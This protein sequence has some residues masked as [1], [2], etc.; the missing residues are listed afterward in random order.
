V[1][2]PGPF[3]EIPVPETRDDALRALATS[4]AEARRLIV[5]ALERGT[6]EAIT[7]V[8]ARVMADEDW[9]VRKQAVHLAVTVAPRVDVIGPLVDALRGPSTEVALRNAAVEA[10]AAIG[11][12]AVE[13]V[14][15]ALNARAADGAPLLDA[16]GRKLAVEVL[17][18]SRKE[19]ALAPVIAALDDDDANVRAAAAEAVGLI[20]GGPAA[21]ALIGLLERPDRFLRLAA[22]EGLDRLGVPIPIDRLAPLVTDRILRH[23]AIAA[24]ARVRDPEAIPLLVRGLGDGS[25]HVAESALRSLGTL[26]GE[27]AHRARAQTELAFA[28]PRA[29]QR[30]LDAALSGDRAL[31][32]LALPVLSVL[33]ALG[34]QAALQAL[35]VALG[36]EELAESAERELREVGEPAIAALVDA[37][38]GDEP[39]TRA[40]VLRLL[41]KLRPHAP[42]ILP[43]ARHALRAR[44]I[45]SG[46]SVA[47]LDAQLDVAAAAASAIAL[48]AAAGVAPTNEDVTTLL[49]A[50][51][52]RTPRMAAAGLQALRALG[53]CAPQAVRPLLGEVEPTSEEAPIVCALLAV[54]GGVDDIGWLGRAVSAESPRTRRA[55]VEALAQIGGTSAAR[56]VALAVTDEVP[57]VSLAAVRAL[58]RLRG[59]PGHE[60][61][62]LLPLLHIMATADD[63]ATVSAAVRALGGTREARA[64]EAIRPLVRAEVPRLACAAVE[65]LAELLA[66]DGA[67]EV[68]ID[69]LGHPAPAVTRAGL[70]VLDALAERQ[71]ARI[72]APPSPRDPAPT[73]DVDGTA[74]ARLAR[75]LLAVSDLLSHPSWEVRR[76]AVEVITRLDPFGARPLLSA[77]LPLEDEPA[78]REVVDRALATPSRPPP[79]FAASPREAREGDG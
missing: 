39:R 27:P 76:R 50:A 23:A 1:T 67:R 32:Q 57:E 79:S 61:P 21:S 54:I 65:A 60:H 22:L 12:P 42:E 31:Q 59:A 72:D 25:R 43:L 13:A 56:A 26:L 7:G 33:G 46:T 28:T 64:V 73:S 62:G 71:E 63:E 75:T 14:E 18:G 58:G 37:A 77:R 15:R 11:L 45:Q 2:S 20:G 34:G 5:C 51:S 35:V 68:A 9:R 30:A 53:R 66:E 44:S 6:A 3:Q 74:R 36:D 47:G 29:R 78:V 16:D 69:A 24:L 41:P 38:R 49:R 70:D 52:S 48:V 19:R 10:L 17:A 40:A 8:L 55:A 4:D